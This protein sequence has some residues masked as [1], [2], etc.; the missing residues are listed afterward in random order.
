[1]PFRQLFP[2]R[3]FPAFFDMLISLDQHGLIILPL[4]SGPK[5][6]P[7]RVIPY[8]PV[9]LLGLSFQPIRRRYSHRCCCCIKKPLMKSGIL[10]ASMDLFCSYR[11]R[12]LPE[13]Y[14]F[15]DL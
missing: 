14:A 9:K 3:G 8:L 2:S 12:L 1:M 6:G 5:L 4:K 11:G 10:A 15:C 7:R 13:R